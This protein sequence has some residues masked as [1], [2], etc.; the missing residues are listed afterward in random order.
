MKTF[1][2]ILAFI[3]VSVFYGYG[4]YS[5]AAV[6]L[7]GFLAYDLF[8]KAGKTLAFREFM[9]TLYGLNYLLSP[10]ITYH[11]PS[12]AVPFYY[13]RIPEEQ[14]FT[15]AIPV[16]LCLR[17]GLFAVKTDIFNFDYQLV[18]LQ[19]LVNQEVLKFWLIAGVVLHLTESFFPGEIG[20]VVYVL[21]TVR[22]IAAFSLYALDRK[23]Y[24]WYL[25]GVLFLEILNGVRTGMFH[26]MMMWMIFFG[27]FWMFL[28]KPSKIKKIGFGVIAVLG[29][30]LLQTSK[31]EF[32]EEGKTEGMSLSTFQSVASSQLDEQ[33]G[34]L[35]DQNLYNSI[36]RVNQAWIF[37]S[38]IHN[39]DYTK[40][41]QGMTLVNLYLE[42]AILPRFLAPNK[43]SSGNRAIFRKFTGYI[44]REG[45]AMA[46]GVPADGY[47]A[48]GY[49]GS[50][51]FA[52][53]LGLLFGAVFKI[54]GNWA[55]I[56]PFFVLFML[57]ILNYAVRPD[58]ETQTI[59]THLV[60]STFIFW[61]L[62]LYYRKYF[63]KRIYIL[64]K[65]EEMEKNKYSGV[66]ANG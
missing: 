62:I 24:K 14:Y 46:M 65:K 12:G 44:V 6:G 51:I 25:L 21:A 8:D 29:Y 33:G 50:L 40:D 2:G 48:Y 10:A 36:N 54:V 26:D 45:T 11:L 13:M 41:F 5:A 3:I 55:K 7:W 22:F 28:N 9:L 34:L 30:I 58:C 27:L 43:L 39:M 56:S 38:T 32:R 52:L 64:E 1:I 23:K 42:A 15:I 20:F 4:P 16:M 18:K 49:W 66:L 53:I 35:K 63:T 19:S 59:I 60:K 37:S 17:W 47:V 57:P 61:M 31:G